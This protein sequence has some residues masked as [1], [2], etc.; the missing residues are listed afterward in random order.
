MRIEEHPVDVGSHGRGR[1]ESHF[2]FELAELTWFLLPLAI[3]ISLY[4]VHDSRTH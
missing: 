4:L 1:D 3:S 2:P